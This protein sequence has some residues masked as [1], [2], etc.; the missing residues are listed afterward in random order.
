MRNAELLTRDEVLEIIHNYHNPIV[1]RL[2]LIKGTDREDLYSQ[3]IEDITS[4]LIILRNLRVKGTKNNRVSSGTYYNY[5][6]DGF[7][8]NANGVIRLA[9]SLLKKTY[10]ETEINNSIPN[11]VY[12]KY[13]SLVLRQ[14]SND[15]TNDNIEINTEYTLSVINS[16]SITEGINNAYVVRRTN[17]TS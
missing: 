11:N 2:L 7:S 10:G 4:Y 15:I 1:M 6:W 8:R 17:E 9:Y 13:Y 3:A 12:S 14:F 5:L 16:Y